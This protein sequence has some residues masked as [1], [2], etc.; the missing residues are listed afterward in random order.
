MS[1]VFAAHAEYD[2]ETRLYVGT[3]PGLPGAHTQ[4]ATLDELRVNLQEVAELILEEQRSRGQST[5]GR[6]VVRIQ[7]IC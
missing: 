5:E 4:G 3:I 6:P 7:E 1:C 2:P